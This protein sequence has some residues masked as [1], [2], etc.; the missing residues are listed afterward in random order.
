MAPNIEELLEDEHARS[1]PKKHMPAIAACKREFHTIDDDRYRLDVPEVGITVE[2]DRLRR[3]HGELNG[4]LSVSC[5]LPGARTYDGS[6]SISDFNLSS[7]RARTDRAKFLALRSNAAEFDWTGLIEEF[8]Q[9]VLRAE[10]AGSPGVDLRTLPR[11]NMTEESHEI[12]GLALPRQHPAI[13]FGDGGCAKS[14]TA[15]FAAGRLAQAGTPVAYFD[16]ELAGE[17]HRDRLERLFPEHMPRILYARC[18]RPLIHEV[19]RL[20]RIVRDNRIGYAVFDSIAFA[21]D[22]PPESA[23]IAGKYFRAVRQLGCGSL[24]VAHVTKGENADKKPFGSTFWHNGARSTWFASA[25][26][27]SREEDVLQIGLFNRKCNLGR[28]RSPTGFAIEFADDRTIFR[29]TNPAGSPELAGQL[30]IR[31]RMLYLLKGGSLDAGRLAD[32]VEADIETIRRTARRYKKQFVVLD[33]G[34]IGLADRFV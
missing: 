14:Y 26:D 2:I 13:L 3:E 24:H 30:S 9:R 21:C 29:R 16:W 34:R 4:E 8:C 10:R 23:E 12:D 15:L 27:G 33:G 22:G 5:D 28:L 18:D 7:A 19:D 11:P 25:A 6:L 31:Q 32:E 1:A 20:R 17:E